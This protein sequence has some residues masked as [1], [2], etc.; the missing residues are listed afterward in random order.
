MIELILLIIWIYSIKKFLDISFKKNVEPFALNHS[1][2][3]PVNNFHLHF[4][5]ARDDNNYYKN[6]QNRDIEGEFK[7]GRNAFGPPG[8]DEIDMKKYY[9]VERD[10]IDSQ[11]NKFD[12]NF[13]V[14]LNYH[15]DDGNKYDMTMDENICNNTNRYFGDLYRGKDDKHSCSE[16]RLR[17]QN[18]IHN[19][20][21][22]ANFAKDMECEYG[23]TRIRHIY[24]KLVDGNYYA[25]PI[26]PRVRANKFYTEGD[27]GRKTLTKERWG[28]VNENVNNGG[29][30]DS[31]IYPVKE[32]ADEEV[33]FLTGMIKKKQPQPVKFAEE[34]LYGYDPNIDKHEALLME[35]EDVK[36]YDE[37]HNIE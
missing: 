23:T 12:Y 13:N 15:Y 29:A 1:I 9:K 2:K 17:D 30:I 7:D 19:A 10:N 22:I 31:K 32:V 18:T 26:K 33:F 20:R 28:Y 37:L 24:D 25:P 5:Q 36:L 16:L 27:N 3:E 14:P 8:E 21:D 34:K 35:N 11:N 4:E 6:Y